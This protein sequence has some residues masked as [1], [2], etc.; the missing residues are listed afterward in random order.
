LAL[1]AALL[2]APALGGV[3][4]GATAAVR[5][6]GAAGLVDMA[7]GRAVERLIAVGGDGGR[8]RAAGGGG[9]GRR[10]DG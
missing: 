10:R 4:L 2:A 8:G 9:D 6:A 1:A 7:D 5:L 3:A